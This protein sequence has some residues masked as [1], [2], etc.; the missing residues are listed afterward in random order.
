MAM[1]TMD[2]FDVVNVIVTRL[3]KGRAYALNSLTFF[4]LLMFLETITLLLET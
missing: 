1:S 4:E 3:S 2:I